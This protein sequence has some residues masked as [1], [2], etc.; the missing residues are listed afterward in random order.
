MGKIEEEGEE[1]NDQG[2]LNKV[3]F[4]E[5]GSEVRAVSRAG[6]LDSSSSSS[7][8]TTD[9][10]VGDSLSENTP[11]LHHHKVEIVAPART[12]TRIP[13]I[14]PSPPMVLE[15][16]AGYD[17]NRIPSSIFAT[18][19]SNPAEWSVASNESLFSIQMGNN[20]F[21][22]EHTAF[23]LYKSGEL[24]KLDEVFSVPTPLPP[25]SESMSLQRD[26]VSSSMA[27][28][29]AK[30]PSTEDDPVDLS[31]LSSEGNSPALDKG[32]SSPPGNARNSVS[33][34]ARS[35][36]SLTTT[37]TGSFAFPR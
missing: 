26:S 7:S 28:N 17:P 33:L 15:R 27:E 2:E 4:H 8:S 9:S 21:S 24:T 32:N 31:K 10:N 6:S 13:P 18:R 34:S 29:S 30:L 3:H 11:I 25:V 14:S 36:G 22:K 35:D 12:P 23:L 19:P 20:S 16:Q 37:S 1:G 5:D